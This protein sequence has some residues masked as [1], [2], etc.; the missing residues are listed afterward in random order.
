MKLNVIFA[1][2]SLLLGIVF[3]TLQFSG[4]SV[5]IFNYVGAFV[6]ASLSGF[7]THKNLTDK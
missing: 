7:F 4:S 3:F 1:A 6:I 2:I 5:T